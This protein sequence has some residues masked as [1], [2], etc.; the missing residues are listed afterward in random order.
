M[1]CID[2][3]N[4]IEIVQNTIIYYCYSVLLLPY[5]PILPYYQRTI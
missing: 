1:N 3:L 2:L 4:Y 5:I